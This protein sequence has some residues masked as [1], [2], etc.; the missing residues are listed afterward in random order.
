M[1]HLKELDY[2]LS[3]EE[4][5]KVKYNNILE[6][7]INFKKENKDIVFVNNLKYEFKPI[8]EVFEQRGQNARVSHEISSYK[9]FWEFCSSHT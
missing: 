7:C 2:F 9:V 3:I 4:D 6:I 5:L 8:R 1:H